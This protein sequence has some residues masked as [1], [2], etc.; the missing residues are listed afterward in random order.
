MALEQKKRL[1]KED[2]VVR[3][4]M[5]GSQPRR[6]RAAGKRFSTEYQPQGRGRPKGSKNVMRRELKEA[7]LAA[8]HAARLDRLSPDITDRWPGEWRRWKGT[9]QIRASC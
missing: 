1:T 7:V 4:L 5:R 8:A 3:R 6:A 2:R 9:W